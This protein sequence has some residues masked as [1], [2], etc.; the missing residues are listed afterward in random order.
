MV[1]AQYNSVTLLRNLEAAGA[2][3][4]LKDKLGQTAIHYAAKAGAL[5]SVKVIFLQVTSNALPVF[6]Y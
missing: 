1:A 5:E 6:A 3:V 4:T 2:S